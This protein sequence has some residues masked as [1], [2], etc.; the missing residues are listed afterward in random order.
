MAEKIN[1]LQLIL[2]AAGK[3]KNL[4][5][6]QKNIII[7]AIALFAER[8]YAATTTSEIARQAGV[9]EGTIFRHYKTKRDLLES[10]ITPEIIDQIVPTLADDF[11]EEVLSKAY[12]SF[13]SFLR[14]LIENRF[15][16]INENRQIMKI[17]ATELF[18]QEELRNNFFV[19]L[20]EKT[21]WRANNIIQYYKDQGELVDMPNQTLFRAMVTNVIG[22]L[23]TRFFIVPSI[24]WDDEAEVDYTIQYITSGII[25]K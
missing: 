11:T 1:L 6:K 21:I 4:S 17:F 25:K 20:K 8:G 19:I 7:A 9:A 10:I 14:Q 5:P 16:F 23:F 24:S 18:Y 3:G 22:F 13:A 15:D 2:D 12:P